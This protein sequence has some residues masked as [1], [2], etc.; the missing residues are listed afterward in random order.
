MGCGDMKRPRRNLDFEVTDWF[1]IVFWI[2]AGLVFFGLGYVAYLLFKA[3]FLIVQLIE[4]L[5]Q[6]SI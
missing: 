5:Q 2:V 1:V 4:Q 3:M 6:V